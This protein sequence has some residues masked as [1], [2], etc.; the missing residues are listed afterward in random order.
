MPAMQTSGKRTSGRGNSKCK[1][2]EA[3]ACEEERASEHSERENIALHFL[4]SAGNHTKPLPSGGPSGW[5]TGP[6]ERI[7]PREQEGSPESA[8]EGRVVHVH[9]ASLAG[10]MC[11]GKGS[12][13]VTLWHPGL[14]SRGLFFP[15]FLGKSALGLSHH[16]A[17]G[18]RSHSP[19]L[20]C[21]QH[22]CRLLGTKSGGSYSSSLLAPR[23]LLKVAGTQK[24]LWVSRK[25][26]E[27]A[28]CGDSRVCPP[29]HYWPFGPD[30]SLLWGGGA[31]LGMGEGSSSSLSHVLDASARSMTHV[32][33]DMA[34]VPRESKVAPR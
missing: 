14:L 13:S 5:T 8:L 18:Q 22:L 30:T 21:G 24:P 7:T 31:V 17:Q 9:M 1:G 29:Q 3:G 34:N 32:S 28:L 10:F 19:K 27:G 2:P 20:G 12:V 4:N 16:K 25:L 11:L 23:R 6:Q 26:W 15:P 33:T